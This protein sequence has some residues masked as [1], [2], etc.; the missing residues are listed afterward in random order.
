ML[1]TSCGQDMALWAAHRCCL[2]G[3]QGVANRR[4]ISHCCA[5]VTDC[6]LPL[7]LSFG[8]VTGEGGSNRGETGE[9]GGSGGGAGGGGR[10]GRQR[11]GGPF[12]GRDRW[13]GG[14]VPLWLRN[15][16]NRRIPGG[17]TVGRAALYSLVAFLAVWATL[18]FIW[19]FCRMLVSVGRGREGYEDLVA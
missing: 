12:A 14:A 16:P 15:L 3:E 6:L 13:H 11:G 4:G 8:E 19:T 5:T 9:G 7:F 18:W 2:M 17:I 1:W 10:K